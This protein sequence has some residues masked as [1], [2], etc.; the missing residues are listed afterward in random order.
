MK[1]TLDDVRG[2]TFRDHETDAALSAE[3]LKNFYL[4][5]APEV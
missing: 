5:A 3:T 2:M 4:R 1:L